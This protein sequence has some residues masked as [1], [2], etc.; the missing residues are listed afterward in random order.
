LA[1]RQIDEQMRA[2]L[3]SL[4]ADDRPDSEQLLSRL[5]ELRAAG[6]QPFSGAVHLLAR[7]EIPE[8]QA[9]RLLRDLLRHREEV[10]RA[11]RRDPGLRV[12][13]IDYLSNVKKLLSNPTVLES[14]QLERTEKS[15][16]TDALTGLYNRRYFEQAL[17]LE[18]RRSRRYELRLT[19]LLLDLDDFKR[20]NDGHGHL[21]GDVVLRRVARVIRR[22]VR[23]ADVA[24]RYGG[25]EFAVILPETDRLGGYAVAERIRRRLAAAFDEPVSGQRVAVRLSGGIASYPRDGSEPE[26]LVARADEALYLSKERGKD[27]ISLYHA[28]RREAVRYP[29][30]PSARV[31]LGHH[32]LAQPVRVRTVNISLHGALLEI[33]CELASRSPV[34]LTF[35]GRDAAGRPRTWPVPGRI[36]RVEAQGERGWPTAV[37]F[38][39]PLAEDCLQQQM[40]RTRELRAVMGGRA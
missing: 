28:E 9:E 8:A 7:V 26:L 38:D 15:A 29:A 16:V 31:L 14:A 35:D 24:C 17:A 4:L 20:V 34:E 18:S 39:A 21:F 32:R 5:D 37:R 12:A 33:D 27:R 19:L 3:A 11:L 36:V 2:R 1:A 6:G 13:A 25:E 40:R 23:D 10:T 30:K 22:A